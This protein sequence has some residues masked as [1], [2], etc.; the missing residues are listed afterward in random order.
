MTM[1]FFVDYHDTVFQLEQSYAYVQ[2][3]YN[4]E[5]NYMKLQQQEE[6]RCGD[7]ACFSG[8]EFVDLYNRIDEQRLEVYEV[9]VTFDDELLN[10]YVNNFAQGKGYLLRSFADTSRLVPFN[11]LQTLPEVRD[12][13]NRLKDE[14]LQEGIALHFVSGFRDLENQKRIFFSKFDM[15]N[16]ENILTGKYDDELALVLERSALPGYSKHHSGYAVDFGCGNDYLVFEFAET[17]CYEWMSHNNFERIKK[18]G[19]I[20][21]YPEGVMYQGPNPE[22]WEYVW[23]GSE[24]LR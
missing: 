23:V 8:E 13:Y 11:G 14:M 17:D 24:V 22:P 15:E 20:P 2:R 16:P 4:A 7:F 6:P 1:V 12:A 9:P 21:S 3:H 5:V 10:T 19:F 18:H